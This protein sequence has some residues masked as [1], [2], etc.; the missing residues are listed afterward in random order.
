MV[1][2]Q[3]WH[4]NH[5]HRSVENVELQL[6]PLESIDILQNLGFG[7]QMSHM[8]TSQNKMTHRIREGF[9]RNVLPFKIKIQKM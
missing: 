6:N 7:E 5:M 4:L 1:I 3:H 8:C 2:I 9:K